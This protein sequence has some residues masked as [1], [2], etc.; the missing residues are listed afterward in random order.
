[1]SNLINLIIIFLMSLI[2]EV[3]AESSHQTSSEK[4]T[5]TVEVIPEEKCSSEEVAL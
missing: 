3:P 2:L 5:A 1:M 4:G